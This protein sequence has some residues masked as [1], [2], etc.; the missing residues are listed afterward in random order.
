MGADDEP[1]FRQPIED[2]QSALAA[3]YA[4]P[5]TIALH[6]VDGMGHALAPEPGLESA[7]QTPHAAEVDEKAVDWFRRYL[8]AHR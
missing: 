2:L 6:V 5:G 1:W 3:R 4:D 8:P 7:P